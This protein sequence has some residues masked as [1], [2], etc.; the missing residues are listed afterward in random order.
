MPGDTAIA[1]M[2]HYLDASIIEEFRG[3]KRACVDHADVR[4]LYDNSNKDFD[5]SYFESFD[6]YQLYKVEMLADTYPL[7]SR[8]GAVSLVPGNCIYPMLLF[9]KLNQSVT[10]IKYYSGE[11]QSFTEALYIYSAFYI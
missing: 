2:A 9:A 11:S 10:V 3:L 4:M 5:P 7:M 8:S 6:E 1:F